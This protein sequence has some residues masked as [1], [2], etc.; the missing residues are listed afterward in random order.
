MADAERAWTTMI[1]A[2]GH[3]ASDCLAALQHGSRRSAKDFQKQLK[4]V[5]QDEVTLNRDLNGS[6]ASPGNP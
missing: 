6:S 4:V 2:S 3:A 5:N 1:A